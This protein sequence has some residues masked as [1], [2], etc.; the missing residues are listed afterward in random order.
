MSIGCYF[1]SIQC[2]FKGELPKTL[3]SMVLETHYITFWFILTIYLPY[4]IR[5]SILKGR[6]V[7]NI[8]MFI[9]KIHSISLNC[10]LFLSIYSWLREI[11]RLAILAVRQSAC[12]IKPFHPLIISIVSKYFFDN[13]LY[14]RTIFFTSTPWASIRFFIRS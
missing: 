4:K 5:A 2:L 13:L 3:K 12:S 6:L 8:T 11:V 1:G 9:A 7:K 14:Y 10:F